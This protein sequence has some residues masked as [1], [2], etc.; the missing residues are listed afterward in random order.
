M[1]VF[2]CYSLSIELR[3]NGQM[4]LIG[5]SVPQVATLWIAAT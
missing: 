5:P 3:F 4:H 1:P 2:S